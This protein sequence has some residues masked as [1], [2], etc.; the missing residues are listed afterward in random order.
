MKVGFIQQ[1]NSHDSKDN[2]EHALAQ[3]ELAQQQGADLV[4]LQELHNHR[5]FCQQE[6]EQYFAL[7]EAIDGPT[8]S[9][10]S[11]AAKHHNIV[12]VGSIYEQRHVGL[13]HNTALVIDSDG[14]LA[15]FYRKMH[16]PD[17]PG[18]YEKYYFTPGD[19]EFLP[20]KT[21]IGNLGVCVCW[22]QWFP[23]SARLMALAG[24]DMLIFPSAIGWDPED[25]DSEKQ[26]QLDAWITIQRSHAIANNL[27]VI[28]VNRVGHEIDES[29]ITQGIEFWGNSFIC[30]GMGKILTQADS[31]NNAMRVININ[32]EETQQL[33]HV[34]PFFRD[35][36]IDAY[37]HLSKRWRDK[38]DN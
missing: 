30:D 17:D 37:A 2:L 10:L 22:D 3:I 4:V 20:I 24:A 5:Y 1:A 8:Q 13:Y 36:R 14:S 19:N 6:N 38:Q 31:Q 32:L 26:R 7:A 33:R 34:W 35:R 12:I 9:I 25:T 29:N 16:I 18:Y 23:E 27:P 28:S 15:G 21:S 11:A